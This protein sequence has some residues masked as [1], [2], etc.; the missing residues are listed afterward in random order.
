MHIGIIGG[1]PAGYVAAIRA[2]QMGAKVSVV[3]KEFLGG[4]CTNHGCIP[5]KALYLTAHKIADFQWGKTM[6]LWDGNI[7]PDWRKI[8]DFKNRVVQRLVKGIEFLFK[9][10]GIELISGRAVFLSPTEILIE[11]AKSE[12]R[13]FD[14]IIIAT[15]S[16]TS[17]PPVEGLSGISPWDNRRALSAEKLPQKLVILGG[18]VI[19]VEFAHIFRAF[20]CDVTI[21]ELMPKILPFNDDDVS[22]AIH[23]ALVKE[24]VKI[25]V[26]AKAVY[27]HR[28][29]EGVI[30]ELDDGNSISAE[31]IIV[32]TGR[33]PVFPDKLDEIGIEIGENGIVVDDFL[34]TSVEDV[35]AAGDVIGPPFLAHLASHQ[36]IFIVERI[37]G[38]SDRKFDGS[39]VPAAIFSALES[40]SAGLTEAEARKKFG[41]NVKIGKFPYIASGR[42][43]CEDEKEGFLKVIA[44]PDGKIIGFHSAGKNSS[45]LLG[46]GGFLVQSGLS[47]DDVED[48]I[49]AHP[50]LSEMIGESV[51]AAEQR[52]IHIL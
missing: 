35:Y 39:G 17:I 28:N 15:G 47:I 31:E 27:A 44:A 1:G 21:V 10:R 11:G 13:K 7:F 22:S 9:K 34:R 20:G 32:A 8:L 45:E 42:A 25:I 52:A 51:L 33:T 24:G 26:S 14:K 30:I 16:T 49:F 43:L 36:G 2:A 19:G 38:E 41:D 46:L 6:S 12:R 23:R 29:T 48:K 18:G 37:L 50:T 40:G 5:T 4:E 3:E